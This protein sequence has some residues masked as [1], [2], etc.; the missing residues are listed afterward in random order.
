[1]ISSLCSFLRADS[2]SAMIISKTNFSS[3]LQAILVFNLQKHPHATA[4][5]KE[6]LVIVI[7]FL[8]F[9]ETT[10]GH[11]LKIS[12]AHNKKRVTL[13]Y[14]PNVIFKR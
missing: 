10:H 13:L 11:L 8:S 2:E 12:I 3:L 9:K 7:P 14:I 1:M 6:V 4:N 5:L